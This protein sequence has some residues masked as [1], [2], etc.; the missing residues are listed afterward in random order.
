MHQ[1][2]R[3]AFLFYLVLSLAN[4]YIRSSVGAPISSNNYQVLQERLHSI[5]E[6]LLNQ[7]SDL[8]DVDELS[9]DAIKHL[10]TKLTTFLLTQWAVNASILNELPLAILA[11]LSPASPLSLIG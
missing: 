4:V 2:H 5:Q 1:T 3:V 9:D 7:T 6:Q 11:Q 10:R 8:D